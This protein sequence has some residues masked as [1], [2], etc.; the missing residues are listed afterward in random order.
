MRG[1]GGGGGDS[2][3]EGRYEGAQGW[4][5]Q[6][7]VCCAVGSSWLT[8]AVPGLDIR[9]DAA[10][11]L[12][13][14]AHGRRPPPQAQLRPRCKS[15]GA[16]RLF[17]SHADRH[18]QTCTSRS[19]RAPSRPSPSTGRPS[20]QRATRAASTISPAG[21]PCSRRAACRGIGWAASRGGSGASWGRRA[22]RTEPIVPSVRR[23][24][25][26]DAGGDASGS[27]GSYVHL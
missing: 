26:R 25:S 20:A 6:C 8:S 13:H 1:W 23:V 10:L 27:S 2:G 17:R 14:G 12:L 24:A 18:R 5:P 15:L 11:H 7:V 9:A 4:F 19:A 3:G 22:R 21:T 16:R